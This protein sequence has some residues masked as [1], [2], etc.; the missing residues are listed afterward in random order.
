[1]EDLPK[2]NIKCSSKRYVNQI[3]ILRVSARMTWEL[4]LRFVDTD[5]Q[6]RVRLHDLCNTSVFKTRSNVSLRF[7]SNSAL[8]KVIHDI[9]EHTHQLALVL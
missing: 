7:G 1:M 8:V 3:S 2:K 4:R 9:Q 5:I 6:Q